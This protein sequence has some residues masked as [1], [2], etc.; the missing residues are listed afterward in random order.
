MS[1]RLD[2]FIDESNKFQGNVI[3]RLEAIKE[4]ID[5]HGGRLSV[6][7]KYQYKTVGAATLLGALS[8][9]IAEWFQRRH[10]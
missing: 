8:G 7:E 2:K 10:P 5:N 6:V 1:E 3:A 9:I 4:R